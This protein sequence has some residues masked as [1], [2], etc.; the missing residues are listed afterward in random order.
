MHLLVKDPL[1]AGGHCF[2]G[3]WLHPCVV[4]Y[5]ALHM[6]KVLVNPSPPATL[7]ISQATV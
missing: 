6:P 1:G 2:Q 5:V 3:P 7:D 4:H